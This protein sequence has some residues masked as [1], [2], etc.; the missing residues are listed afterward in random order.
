MDST[1]GPGEAR[2][3]HPKFRSTVYR[4]QAVS[5]LLVIL[6]TAGWGFCWAAG[7]SVV[8]FYQP[9]LGWLLLGSIGGLLT[10]LV[11]RLA[12][13][14]LEGKQL[15]S[16]VIGWSVGGMVSAAFANYGILLGWLLMGT[17]GA[18]IS[19]LVIRRF[20]PA[21]RIS[22]VVVAWQLGGTVAAGFLLVGGKVIGPY[23]GSIIGGYL[24]LGHRVAPFIVWAIIWAVSG[25]ITGAIGGTCTLWL[26]RPR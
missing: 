12:R 1:G 10:A 17:V 24:A 14:C 15:L 3:A 18:V 23:L 8:Y 6:T 16:V 7:L 22:V 20:L 11:F 26:V 13:P 9:N 4:P 5:W 2:G 25:G 19:G 21:V